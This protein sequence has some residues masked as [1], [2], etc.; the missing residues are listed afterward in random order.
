[1]KL[2]IVRTAPFA[3]FSFYYFYGSSPDAVGGA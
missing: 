3:F 1:M 2:K